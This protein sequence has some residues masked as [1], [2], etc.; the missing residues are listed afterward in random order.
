[1]TV[2]DLLELRTTF[3]LGRGAATAWDTCRTLLQHLGAHKRDVVAAVDSRGYLARRLREE[4]RQERLFI[5]PMESGHSTIPLASDRDHDWKAVRRLWPA[6]ADTSQRRLRR[7]DGMYLESHNVGLVVV[8]GTNNPALVLKGAGSLVR[9]HASMILLDLDPI[10]PDKRLEI[11]T[12]CR[13]ILCDHDW[14]DS[15]LLPVAD[16]D[17]AKTLITSAAETVFALLPHSS[18]IPWWN[19]PPSA[20]PLPGHLGI[21]LPQVAWRGWTMPVQPEAV[22]QITIQPDESFASVG[23]YQP[24]TDGSTIWRWSGPSKNSRFWI[25]APGYG[26]WRLA[27]SVFSWGVL[28]G[29]QAVQLAVRGGPLVHPVER[30]GRLLSEPVHI[31]PHGGAR[32][33]DVDLVC[34]ELRPPTNNDPRRLG[35][36]VSGFS[37]E[38]VG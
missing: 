23:F 17:I 6:P 18:A 25:P 5:H 8:D 13:T 35:L 27:L 2:N 26:T 37:L 30:L 16:V 36:C 11:A 29:P 19:T 1:M 10:P 24:E 31:F 3:S 4:V 15:L 12:A 38:R 21:V 34:S 9:Q 32:L 33:L 22:R 14:Y 28:P 7:L 20:D